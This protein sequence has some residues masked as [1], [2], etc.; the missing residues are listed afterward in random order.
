[1]ALDLYKTVVVFNKDLPRDEFQEME[2]MLAKIIVQG[3]DPIL[4]P[5]PSYLHE[6][7]GFGNTKVKKGEQVW[8]G[9]CDY[10][11]YST[12]K[13]RA[14]EVFRLLQRSKDVIAFETV[15]LKG[16]A[17][18]KIDTHHRVNVNAIHWTYTKKQKPK[19]TDYFELIF[20]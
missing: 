7:K 18:A 3:H 15:I 9:W 12:E 2:T 10:F 8:Y 5:I 11:Y 14:D 16:E 19:E 17:A 20:C 1:M 13:E 6:I 4:E